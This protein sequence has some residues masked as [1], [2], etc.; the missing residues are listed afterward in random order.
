MS[1]STTQENAPDGTIE[2][3]KITIRVGPP[4]Q[5]VTNVDMWPPLV[6]H[7]ND[8]PDL[9]SGVVWVNLWICDRE[10]NPQDQNILGGQGDRSIYNVD[11]HYYAVFPR[12]TV[13]TPGV[14]KIRVDLTSLSTY[15]SCEYS[16]TFTILGG[17]SEVPIRKLG[18]F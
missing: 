17:S 13:S 16:K 5:W 8:H 6:I 12:L 10:G 2:Q 11:G 9:Q 14:Y 4:T 1:S 15:I 3:G 7:C 18:K